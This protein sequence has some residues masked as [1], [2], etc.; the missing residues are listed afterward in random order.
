MSPLS[1]RNWPTYFSRTGRFTGI[2]QTMKP[3][4]TDDEAESSGQ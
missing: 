3:D 1:D 4:H 2:K